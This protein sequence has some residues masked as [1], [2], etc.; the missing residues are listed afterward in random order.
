MFMAAPVSWASKR[1]GSDS[2]ISCEIEYMGLT[3][4]AQEVSYLGELKGEMDGV[5]GE[6]EVKCIEIL[7]D[8]QSAKPLW[9]RTVSTMGG[10]S[11]SGSS[12]ISSERGWSWKW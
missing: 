6:T 7:T 2:L 4:A 9:L 12:G 5:R 1:V 3:L 11:I 8:G 10:P